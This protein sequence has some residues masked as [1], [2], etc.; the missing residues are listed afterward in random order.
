[1][2]EFRFT[3]SDLRFWVF[4]CEGIITDGERKAPIGG[5]CNRQTLNIP[6]LILHFFGSHGVQQSKQFGHN[7]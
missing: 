4:Y 5:D 7:L 3:V 2:V 1:M 6:Q